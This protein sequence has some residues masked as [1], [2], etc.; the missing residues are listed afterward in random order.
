MT[1]DTHIMTHAAAPTTNHAAPT[2]THD[3]TPGELLPHMEGHDYDA[4]SG[5]AHSTMRHISSSTYLLGDNRAEIRIKPFGQESSDDV[6]TTLDEH[7]VNFRVD[8]NT[9][10]RWIFYN[11][12]TDFFEVHPAH[13]HLTS[14]FAVLDS[15]HTSP[16]NRV[17]EFRGSMDMYSVKAG[18]SLAADIHF[19]LVNSVA[20]GIEHLQ[21]VPHRCYMCHCHYMQH[22]DLMMMLQFY[23]RPP[24]SV[25]GRD[26]EAD[27]PSGGRA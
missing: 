8:Q 13:F 16:I 15:A 10:E 3:D 22:H 24:P 23:V 14:G 17:P 20:P 6:D 1:D 2:I 7:V 4:H 19:G 11:E 25:S 5:T 21:Y 27:S 9:T 12:D 18:T 26:A